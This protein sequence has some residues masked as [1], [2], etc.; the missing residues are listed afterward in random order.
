[1]DDNNNIIR[2]FEIRVFRYALIISFAFRSIRLVHEYMIGSPLHVMLVGLLNILLIVLVFWFHRRYYVLGMCLFYF[3]VLLTSVL[4]WNDAGGWNGSVPYILLVV[5]VGIIIT[6]HGV[7]QIVTLLLYGMV[8]ILFAYTDILELYSTPNENYSNLSREMDFLIMTII[9]I[10]IT[11]YLKNNFFSFRE[12]AVLNNVRLSESSRTLSDQNQKL[13]EQ[14]AE[15]NAIRDNLQEITSL[16]IR[17]VHRKTET[18]KEYAFI[19]A[20]H[21]RGPLARILGL[22]TLIELENPDQQKSDALN[23]IKREAHEM[24]GIIGRITDVIS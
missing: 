19:N 10:S 20:H 2:G 12:S 9:L 8:L 16:K 11:L 14:Q 4:T 3:Q 15:L 23:E 18:L 13:K 6:S 21:V 5:S 1:M 22:I 7:F 17:E 24:D